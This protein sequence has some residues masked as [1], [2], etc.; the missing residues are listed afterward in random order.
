[1]V[2]G[3]AFGGCLNWDSTGFIHIEQIN[4]LDQS[5][6]LNFT[7]VHWAVIFS[8][9]YYGQTPSH[10]LAYEVLI[11]LMAVC[12]GQSQNQKIIM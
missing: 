9:I 3:S 11:I 6:Q 7:L 5:K 8:I 12:P 10:T 4:T 1:M 2:D